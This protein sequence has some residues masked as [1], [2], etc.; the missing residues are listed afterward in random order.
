MFPREDVADSDDEL[1]FSKVI[2]FLKR[3][4]GPVSSGWVVMGRPEI[5]MDVLESLLMWLL[6]LKRCD[7]D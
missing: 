5:I 2:G 4:M 1:Q 7:E 3:Q 6:L